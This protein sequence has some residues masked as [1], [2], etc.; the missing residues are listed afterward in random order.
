MFVYPFVVYNLHFFLHAFDAQFE[1]TAFFL[2]PLSNNLFLYNPVLFRSLRKNA[3]KNR[4]V[5]TGH[6]T[7][8]LYHRPRYIALLAR[9][10]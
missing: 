10:I 5:D 4:N 1:H 8:T 3:L 6:D 7:K 9:I 2:K